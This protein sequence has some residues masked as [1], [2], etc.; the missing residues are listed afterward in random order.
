[1]TVAFDAAGTGFAAGAPGNTVQWTHVVGGSAIAVF[2][3][4]FEPSATVSTVDC[5]GVFL[6][7]SQLVVPGGGVSF[8][9]WGLASPPTGSQTI[10]VTMS[11]TGAFIAGGSTSC[12]GSDPTTC[13]DSTNN[14]F[15]FGSSVSCAVPSVAGELVADAGFVDGNSLTQG[16]SQTLQWSQTGFNQDVFGSTIAAA[17]GTTTTTWNLVGGGSANLFILSGS[18][19]LATSPPTI[20]AFGLATTGL[21]VLPCRRKTPPAR[22]SRIIGWRRSRGLIVPDR[23]LIAA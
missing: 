2:L 16:G 3:F 9:L 10:T 23:R 12:T 4:N 13:F 15:N 18:F 5:G 1:M 11:G 19:K 17:A 14:A 7:Q 21:M 8:Q 20:N 22:R 6:T